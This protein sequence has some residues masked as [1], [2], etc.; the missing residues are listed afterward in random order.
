MYLTVVSDESTTLVCP[1]RFLIHYLPWGFEQYVDLSWTWPHPD[2]IVPWSS[3]GLGG[4]AFYYSIYRS[5]IRFLGADDKLVVTSDL[6]TNLI[7]AWNQM[8]VTNDFLNPDTGLA[9]P[10]PIFGTSNFD[11]FRWPRVPLIYYGEEQNFYLYDST[12][13]N[14]L[15]LRPSS[16]DEQQGLS[17]LMGCDDD[18]N[19]L[20]HFDPT[21]DMRRL[22]KHFLYPGT[23]YNAIQDGFELVQLGN[24]TYFVEF[25]G[26]NSTATEL[27]LWS[28]ITR[29]Y[30]GGT[31]VRNLRSP[32]ENY[33][34][35]D[36][37]LSYHNNGEGPWY[38]VHLL[39]RKGEANNVMVF[40]E[41][42]Y[43]RRFQLH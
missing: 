1:S 33:T 19:S 38:V 27:G 14:Y 16:Y 20:D 42:D 17:T 41:S 6:N 24:W 13:S 39:L 22:L 18:W 32:Y 11:V 37:G 5:L 35:V 43:V 4:Y 8:L 2:Y 7:T 29:R 21:T 31:T 28:R 34:L 23:T 12:V 15:S 30:V 3:N 40:P 10:K 36:S 26:S 9:D 25:P